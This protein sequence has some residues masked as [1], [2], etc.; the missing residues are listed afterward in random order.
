MADG[1]LFLRR[2]L[3][4]WW[5]CVYFD[6]SKVT[7]N[8]YHFQPQVF[9]KIQFSRHEEPINEMA[10][11]IKRSP[12]MQWGGNSIDWLISIRQTSEPMLRQIVDEFVLADDDALRKRI[13]TRDFGFFME[14]LP[15]GKQ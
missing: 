10:D 12:P 8:Y 1:L 15:N 9:V 2:Y 4:E 6:N 14:R 11:L 3:L 7:M 13:K 5:D